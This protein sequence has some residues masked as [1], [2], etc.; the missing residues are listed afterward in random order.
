MTVSQCICV[1]QKNY[2][3]YQNILQGKELNA[4][5]HC[6][7]MDFTF[8][9]DLAPNGNTSQ[10][11][12]Y[13]N[14]GVS[15]EASNAIDGMTEYPN[16]THTE[17]EA[18]PFLQVDLTKKAEVF[19]ITVFNR[20]HETVSEIQFRLRNFSILVGESTDKFET[21]VTQ[22]NM[23]HDVSK[24]FKCHLFGRFVKLQSHV[25]DY[26]NICEIMILGRYVAPTRSF[27]EDK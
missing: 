6:A 10:S 8:I 20:I 18:N 27:K 12:I 11:S 7:V 9:L 2:L 16:C 4:V 22:E 26:L 24:T 17:D 3:F 14:G 21:C 13:F 5:M 19:G 1:K 25:H 15:Y 23:S